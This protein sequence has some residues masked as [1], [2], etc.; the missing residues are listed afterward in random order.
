MVMACHGGI[1]VV[2]F[3]CSFGAA[4]DKALIVDASDT[5]LI[6]LHAAAKNGHFEVLEF[7]WCQMFNSQDPNPCNPV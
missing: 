5:G 2:K 6:P 7:S 4:T 1:Q 3:L